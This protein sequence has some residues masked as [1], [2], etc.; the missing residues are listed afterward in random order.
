MPSEK[1][2]LPFKT[3]LP[4]A[5]LLWLISP[6]FY[7]FWQEAAPTSS[8]LLPPLSIGAR[9]MLAP[10]LIVEQIGYWLWP[11]GREPLTMTL[12][13]KSVL[14]Q[15]LFFSLILVL[16][17]R[18]SWRLRRIEPW[19]FYGMALS[20]L[21]FLPY[22]GV[23]PWRPAPF[24]YTP[25]LFGGLGL[26]LSIA[27]LALRSLENTRSQGSRPSV[28]QRLRKNT[29]LLTGLML[30]AW[31][32]AQS[33]N[34]IVVMGRSWEQRLAA[35]D[36]ASPDLVIAVEKARQ[37]ALQG[38]AEEAELLI[39][40]CGQ[41]APWYPEV[42]IVMAEMLIQQGETDAALAHLERTLKLQPNQSRARAMI[43]AIKATQETPTAPPSEPSP[44]P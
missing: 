34:L 24:S 4:L 19:L 42:P 12:D 44:A 33:V 40:R 7:G 9:L 20:V 16:V 11:L 38:H 1:R 21:G 28:K 26:A 8:C 17:I 6:S 15:G 5:A 32:G 13:P 36:D 3:L 31:L 29:W 39:I 18:F 41:A 43:A 30:I 14:R 2:K 22:S 25:L 10:Q 23:I 37:S 27:A 35:M